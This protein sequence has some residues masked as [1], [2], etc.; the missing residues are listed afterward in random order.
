M[1][2]AENLGS[3]FLNALTEVISTVSGFY[4]EV[5]SSEKDG[6]FNEMTGA[7]PLNGEKNGML[8]ISADETDIRTLCS[9]MT[10]SP[11]D[12]ITPDD[13]GDTVCELVNMTA[14]NAKLRLSGTEYGFE[15]SP[16]FAVKGAGMTL[17]TKSRT[18]VI[19]RTLGNGEI[20]VKIKLVY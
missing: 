14:G 13:V 19:S 6:G 11:P 1:D 12:E 17:I 4:L 2:N 5:M 16:P 15:L 10:G 7:M 8:F 18:Q 9:Y 3:V 20:T